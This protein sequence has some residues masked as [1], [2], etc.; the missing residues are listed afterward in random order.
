MHPSGFRWRVAAAVAAIFPTLCAATATYAAE[1]VDYLRDIKPIL[2][3]RCYG[4]HGA[5]KQK[6]GLRVDTAA[7][8]KKGSDGGTVI[9]PGSSADSLIIDA[10]TGANGMP[11]MPPDGQPLTAA[12]IDLLKKWIDSGAEAPANEPIPTDPEKH[13]SFQPPMRPELPVVKDPAWGRNPIDT[14]ITAEHEHRG[15]KR[16]SPADPDVLLRR[17]YLDLIGI[18]PTRQ[19]L[20]DF[21]ADKSPTAYEDVVDRL[22]ASPQYGERWGRHWMDVWRYSD[23]DGYRTEVRQ[24]QPY[25]WRWRDW[26]IE[27]LN[28]DKGYD[29]MVQEM[30]AGDELAPADPQT[31]RATG[32]LV[33][34]WYKFNRNT[35]LENTVEHTSKAFLGLTLNCARCHDHLFDPLTQQE[36]Y[37]FRAIFESHQVRTDRVSEDPNLDKN[38]LVRIF[39]DAAG[40]P[41]YLF[42]RGDDK[43]PHKDQPL[44]PGIPAIL[45][46][47]ELQIQPV[48]LPLVAYYPGSRDFVQNAALTQAQATLKARQ[49]AE[50][51]ADQ[52]LAAARQKRD[53]YLARQATPEAPS[54]PAITVL[55]DNFATVN[56]E[57]WKAGKGKWEHKEGRLF[58]TEPVADLCQ[59]TAVRSHPKNFVA[60]LRFRITGGM[61]WKSAGLCF[62]VN[63]ADARSFHSVYISAHTPSPKI[64]LW[65]RIEGADSYPASGRRGLPIDLNREYEIEVAVRDRLVNVSLNGELQIVDQL[66]S[67]RAEKGA[68]SVWTY[69]ATAEFLQV[70]IT[71]LPADAKL[72]DKVGTPINPASQASTADGLAAGILQAEQALA[73]AKLEAA[74][75]Q[76]EHDSVVARMAADA[77]ND[78]QPPAANAKELSL[79]AGHS[80]QELN[81]SKTALAV[82][83]AEQQLTVA[84]G[85]LPASHD[86]S[87]ADKQQAGNSKADKQKTDKQQKEIKAA[88][89]RLAAARKSHTAAVAAAAKPKEQYTRFSKVYPATSTGRRLA[90]AR[91]IT[92]DNNPLAARVAV[93]HIWMR[94]FGSPLVSTVFDF[95]LHGKAPS[96]PQLLD[97]LAVEFIEQGW[98]M[99]PLHRLL[100][101]SQAYR[102]QSASGADAEANRQI[103]PENRYLWRANVRRMEAE[104]VRDSTLAVAGSLDRTLYGPDL[105]HTDDLKI[106]RRSIYFRSSKEKRMTFVSTFDSANVNECYR[107]SESIVPQQALAMANSSLTLGQSRLLS[108]Q[109][110]AEVGPDNTP[111]NVTKFISFAFEQVLN[112]S[113]SDLERQECLKF[114][115]Q[116]TSQFSAPG[117]LT[118]FGETDK[119]SIAPATQPHL[120]AR[121]NLVHV[122]LNHNDFVTIR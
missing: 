27:S 9:E 28:A 58:Q 78:A 110:S 40:S 72:A 45:G 41:T 42:E 101:T 53:D 94:H 47:E 99:K 32:Y 85:A 74:V 18:P 56:A 13:W 46:T 84:Q 73:I 44:Q 92:A 62:D 59:M 88:E 38:G 113:P 102:L 95:G 107:R 79:A 76:A 61:N 10:V 33:R 82:L 12:Q 6:S 30:L 63:G 24:S 114:V 57:L 108:R 86:K 14:F 64:Q 104:I 51:Q 23:W 65:H 39:D 109:L 60:R 43:R 98:K 54:K 115:Q 89:T 77:A 31:A 120:R 50:T 29:R 105:P 52:A 19:E 80:E 96:H 36:Y 91:W 37:E 81:V 25:I 117:S 122:L 15:L 106:P 97:W 4:C 3:Q 26:I 112:R 1:T 48:E 20:H 119:S 103:D 116:Q 17:V 7:L 11:R 35:W 111:Q 49:T 75:A 67:A 22:L 118:P 70:S 68:F 21:L 55:A 69:D 8:L 5:L 2:T 87:K 83:K 93:N 34:N 100:V 16:V 121:E 90:L 66:P 71:E